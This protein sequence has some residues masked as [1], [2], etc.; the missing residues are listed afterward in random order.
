MK[1]YSSEDMNAIY[2]TL[3]ITRKQLR[4]LDDF[5]AAMFPIIYNADR[6]IAADMFVQLFG[7]MQRYGHRN[8]TRMRRAPRPK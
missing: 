1:K 3:T 2:Y 5:Q 4:K 8:T 7:E 6:L